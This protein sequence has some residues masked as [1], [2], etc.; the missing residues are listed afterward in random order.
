MALCVRCSPLLQAIALASFNI[1]GMLPVMPGPCQLFRY[2][3]ITGIP[4]DYYFAMVNQNPEDGGMVVGNL[5]LAEDR[6]L[7][8]A[9]VLLA[10]QE[11][12]TEWEPKSVF[13]FDPELSTN[14]VVTQ[15]RRWNNGSIAGFYYLLVQH[16][17]LIWDSLQP[18]WRKL[19]MH[20]FF[21]LM[22]MTYVVLLLSPA[23]F[24]TIF[25]YSLQLLEDHFADTW[26]WITQ[27]KYVIVT[28]YMVQYVAWVAVHL[29]KKYVAWFFHLSLWTSVLLMIGVSGPII[30]TLVKLANNGEQ[31]YNAEMIVFTPF[32][33]LVLPL[34]LAVVVSLASMKEMLVAFIPYVLFLPMMLVSLPAYSIAR[35]HDLR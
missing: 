11:Q 4:L 15:R 1:S 33:L 27:F 26:G 24:C 34:P 20:T 13:Y 6:I 29:H 17:S 16:P 21:M 25:F 22:T 14:K 3:P 30:A 32:L 10:E 7:S 18:F 28:Y 19:F 31:A 2:K 23:V 8:E 35:L 9:V 12:T 5:L